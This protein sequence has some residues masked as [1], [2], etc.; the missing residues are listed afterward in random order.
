MKE[1]LIESTGDSAPCLHVAHMCSRLFPVWTATREGNPRNHFSQTKDRIPNLLE[2]VVD[3]TPR[4]LNKNYKIRVVEQG[5]PMTLFERLR[6]EQAHFL[7]TGEHWNADFWT[8]CEGSRCY[9][10][11]TP[12]VRWFRG[13][14]SIHIRTTQPPRPDERIL[15]V[16]LEG[17]SA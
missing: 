14:L 7:Q 10:H 12:I 8:V 9:G 4:P 2:E 11:A 6:I 17:P 15:Y 16:S 3:V 5:E 1:L 13:V